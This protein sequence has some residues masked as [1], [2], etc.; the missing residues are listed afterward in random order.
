MYAKCLK[1][2]IESEGRGSN[3][4]KHNISFREFK[5]DDWKDVHEY[6]SQE[7]VCI[8]Q[9]WGP[10]NESESK[11]YVKRIIEDSHANPRNRYVFAVEEQEN[12]TVIGAGEINLRDIKNQK[13]DI[14]YIINPQYWGKGYATEVASYL[15]HFGFTKLNLHRIYATCDPRNAASS[16]VLE[17]IGMQYEGKMRE[18]MLIKDGWRDS[19]LYSILEKEWR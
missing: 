14:A 9:P 16:K 11:E 3:L 10:N 19:S 17:K 4:E 13:G 5:F 6:A 12:N 1:T 15:L 18:V 7:R 2:I 8:Y